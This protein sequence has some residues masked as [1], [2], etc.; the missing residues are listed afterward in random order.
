MLQMFEQFNCRGRP[1]QYFITLVS[2]LFILSNKLHSIALYCTVL[3]VFS[4]YATRNK[5]TV[6][7]GVLAHYST[8]A[9][10]LLPLLLRSVL[11]CTS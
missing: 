1:T 8:C 7:Q 5:R 6:V 11:Y 9:L 10:I 2:H 3:R 4:L